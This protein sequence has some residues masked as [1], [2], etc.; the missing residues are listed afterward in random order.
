MDLGTVKDVS[1]VVAGVVAF[2][3]FVGGIAEYWR[4]NREIRAEHFIAMRRRFLET[5]AYKEILDQ[6]VSGDPALGQRSIQ[7]RRN[8]IGFLEEIGLMIDSRLIQAQVA[9]YM[10]GHYVRLADG[11]EH[12]WTDLDKG[13]EYWAVFR[14]L[15]A[16]VKAHSSNRPDRFRF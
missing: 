2:V 3:G 6:I 5:P 11:S 12:L 4:R 16:Q 9:Y 8:F 10:F 13:G 15:A 7:E 14:R 1:I